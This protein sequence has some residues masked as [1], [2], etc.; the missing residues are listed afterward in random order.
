MGNPRVR[1]SSARAAETLNVD[2]R[3]VLEQAVANERWRIL[4]NIRDAA[5]RIQT[6]ES[7]SRSW[8]KK[9]RPASAFKRDLLAEIGRLE[10]G[11]G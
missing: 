8:E 7:G 2:Y 9:D 6:A 3:D 5:E 1:F 4:R 11:D 10:R